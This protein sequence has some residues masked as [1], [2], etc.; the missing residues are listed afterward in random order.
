MKYS[1]KRTCL[2]LWIIKMAP[3]NE[4]GPQ[5]RDG[6]ADLEVCQPKWDF[7]LTF[8]NRASYI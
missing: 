3:P 7:K 6:D 5:H 4:L 8:K 2:V 1:S